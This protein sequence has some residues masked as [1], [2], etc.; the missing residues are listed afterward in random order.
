MKT[1]PAK[2]F[3]FFT[4]EDCQNIVLA[5]IESGTEAPEE[6][7]FLIDGLRLVISPWHPGKKMVDACINSLLQERRVLGLIASNNQP[8]RIDEV[9]Y[10]Q[11]G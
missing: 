7:D 1:G 8:W 9:R 10:C 4:I 5:R 11:D 6:I 2:K 3:R